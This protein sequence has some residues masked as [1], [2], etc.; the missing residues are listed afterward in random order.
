MTTDDKLFYWGCGEPSQYGLYSP[1]LE[2]FVFVDHHKEILE[3]V[4]FLLSSKIRLL[5]VK[6]DSA[7]NF[8]I[9]QIDNTCCSGWG[10]V[11]WPNNVLDDKFNVLRQQD[12]YLTETCGTLTEMIKKE[13]DE[14][15]DLAF[16]SAH[17]IRSL[18]FHPNALY[19][20]FNNMIDLPF[21]DYSRIK[22]IEKECY[23][24]IYF[25]NKCCRIKDQIIQMCV[26]AKH[27]LDLI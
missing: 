25:S 4:M 19:S 21:D 12:H 1:V 17:V 7:P 6:I 10:V 8:K 15:Q 23:R 20:K 2:R 24:L 5:V 3:Y 9:N 13:I 18:R 26:D 22:L 27:T 11:A 14:I 16:L